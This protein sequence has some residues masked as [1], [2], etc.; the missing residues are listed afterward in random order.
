MTICE[1]SLSLA[2]F[3]P[4][5]GIC[6]ILD[7]AQ[8][9]L[10]SEIGEAFSVGAQECWSLARGCGGELHRSRWVIQAFFW[11]TGAIGRFWSAPLSVYECVSDQFS[12]VGRVTE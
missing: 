11:V 2:L 7:G 8:G 10:C 6:H 1:L 12:L 5:A 9:S 4:I 3:E